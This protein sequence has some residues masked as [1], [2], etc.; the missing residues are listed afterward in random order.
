MV[1]R[2]MYLHYVVDFIVVALYNCNF[3]IKKHLMFLE[4]ISR[5]TYCQL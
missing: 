4:F 1:V 2:I 3:T 5:Q